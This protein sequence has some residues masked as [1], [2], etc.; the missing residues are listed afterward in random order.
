MMKAR[1]WQKKVENG[2]VEK[3]KT[4]FDSEA[5]TPGAWQ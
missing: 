1:R 5:E 4:A 3:V 2:G